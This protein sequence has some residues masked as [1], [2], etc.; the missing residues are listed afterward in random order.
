MKKSKSKQRKMVKE[1]GFYDI[2]GCKPDCTNDEIKKGIQTYCI[3]ISSRQKSKG[4]KFKQISM[5]YATLSDPE[6]RA[7][8]DEGGEA[9]IKKGGSGAQPLSNFCFFN[10]FFLIKTQKTHTSRQGLVTSDGCNFRAVP[11]LAL[12]KSIICDKCNSRGSKKGG[13]VDKCTTCRGTG[14][15]TKVQRLGTGFVQQFEQVCSLCHGQDEVISEKDHCNQCH[16][17]KTI[18]DRTIIEENLNLNI[19]DRHKIEFSGEGDQ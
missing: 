12:Q 5:A 18:R 7:I 10:R 2:L 1:T 3:K 17:K 16:G 14:V 9:A 6:K 4:E 13:S 8:Y 19:Q 11:K 15:E